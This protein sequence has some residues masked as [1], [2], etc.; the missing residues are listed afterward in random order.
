[1]NKIS[2]N[3]DTVVL[4][5]AHP[6]KFSDVVMK[7]TSIKPDL[8]EN[9]KKILNQKERIDKLPNNLNKVKNYI[10]DRV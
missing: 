8:P 7:E 4:A 2:L 9:L 3:N 6:A 5:T 1:M 10:L